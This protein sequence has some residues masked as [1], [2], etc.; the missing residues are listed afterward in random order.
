M[1]RP[2]R[3]PGQQVQTL[4]PGCACTA[5]L[6]TAKAAFASRAPLYRGCVG[7]GCLPPQNKVL[8]TAKAI[9][10]DGAEQSEVAR[11]EVCTDLQHFRCSHDHFGKQALLV[12]GHVLEQG[13][14]ALVLHIV[15]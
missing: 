4:A 15:L 5:C 14:I 8:T 7:G 13:H 1:V 12:L 9:N 6:Q 10:M 11:G 2:K 3:C